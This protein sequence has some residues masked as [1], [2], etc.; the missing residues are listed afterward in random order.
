MWKTGVELHTVVTTNSVWN[1][2]VYIVT[3][4]QVVVWCLPLHQPE[5]I[6][7]WYARKVAKHT[8]NVDMFRVSVIWKQS[9]A[10]VLCWIM[11][12]A[13]FH[14]Y[15]NVK[16]HACSCVY[17][18]TFPFCVHTQ[19]L[20]KLAGENSRTQTHLLCRFSVPINEMVMQESYVKCMIVVL[21]PHPHP[22]FRVWWW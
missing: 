6:T 22:L 5:Y 14:A 11:Q 17:A 3:L 4:S 8:M 18:H 13:P 12:L 7:R 9:A 16:L 10:T 15:G 2:V 21:L 19:V 20:Q 1:S